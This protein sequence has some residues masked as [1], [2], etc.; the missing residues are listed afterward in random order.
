MQSPSNGSESGPDSPTRRPERSPEE[1]AALR[2]FF[3]SLKLMESEAQDAAKAARDSLP[4]LVDAAMSGGSQSRVVLGWLASVYNS[5]EAP[6]VQLDDIRTLDWAL[7]KPL[8]AVVLG[9]AA[10]DMSDVEIRDA[11]RAH[12]EAAVEALHDLTGGGPERRALRF[13]ATQLR[14][15]AGSDDASFIREFLRSLCSAAAVPL[16]LSLLRYVDSTVRD[17]LAV[18][19]DGFC[20]GKLEGSDIEE[21]LR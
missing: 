11:C 21:V 9:V 6:R 10:G 2:D 12:S 16:N 5:S 17:R 8:L 14:P 3:S 20:E 7:R 4:V 18:V 1:T 15:D 19:F 13:L